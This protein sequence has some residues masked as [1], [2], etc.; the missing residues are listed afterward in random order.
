[1]TG[2]G[3]LCSNVFDAVRR[4]G[5]ANEHLGGVE[6]G[7]AQA[8]LVALYQRMATIKACDDRLRSMLSTGQVACMDSSPRGQEAVAAAETLPVGTLIARIDEA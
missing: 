5:S 2:D 7:H 4:P 8:T 1:M 3:E 6:V